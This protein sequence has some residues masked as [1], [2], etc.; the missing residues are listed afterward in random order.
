MK[1]AHA[2]I[3]SVLIAAGCA[4]IAK[5]F[6]NQPIPGFGVNEE[7]ATQLGCDIDQIKADAK[8]YKAEIRENGGP[9]YVVIPRIGDTGCDVLAKLG[10]PDRVQTIQTAAT[11]G[12]NLWYNTGSTQTYDYRSHLV[13]LGPDESETRFVV[14][15]VVW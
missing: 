11:V 1:R 9:P 8:T 3:A 2:L 15:S 13:T 14:T 7:M 6:V 5:A 10:R 4:S 12:L